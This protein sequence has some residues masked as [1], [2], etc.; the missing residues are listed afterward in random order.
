M[1]DRL[2]TIE[3]IRNSG[4]KIDALDEDTFCARG[5]EPFQT[6]DVLEQFN[7][8]R[9]FHRTTILIE[10]MRQSVYGMK[11]P[12]R[13]R[14]MVGH[15]SEMAARRARELASMDEH[16]VYGRM[17]RRGSFLSSFSTSRGYPPSILHKSSI[18]GENSS[19]SDSSR[20]ISLEDRI[21]ELQESNARRLIEIYSQPGYNPFRFPLR[22]DSLLGNNSNNSVN[23]MVAGT[24]FNLSKNRF[25]IRRDSLTPVGS[26]GLR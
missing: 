26:T 11:F 24:L 15:Q 17:R 4:G 7:S 25:P 19:S 16:A 18:D 10:Q 1:I 8:D 3:C 6:P 9:S 14:M 22:R 13:F 23:S 20:S 2:R 5:L 21:R 12:E